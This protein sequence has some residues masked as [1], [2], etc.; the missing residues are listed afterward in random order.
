MEER[1]ENGPFYKCYKISK[2]KN[3]RDEIRELIKM[4]T[5]ASLRERLR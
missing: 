4:V 3:G 5:D 2:K 1:T